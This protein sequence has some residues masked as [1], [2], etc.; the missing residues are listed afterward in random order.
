MLR[1][2][3]G[4]EMDKLKAIEDAAGFIGIEPDRMKAAIDLYEQTMK[5]QTHQPLG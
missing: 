3:M 5:P 2:S 1:R 4:T